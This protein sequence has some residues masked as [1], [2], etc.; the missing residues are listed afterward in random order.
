MILP[1]ALSLAL[2]LAAMA[3]AA[4]AATASY[5]FYVSGIKVGTVTLVTDEGAADYS[6]RAK[7][8][9]AGLLGVFLSFNYDGN[10]QGALSGGKPVPT[11]FTAT[12]VTSGTKKSTRIDWA[13]GAPAKVT[14]NPPRS[15]PLN[16]AA[17]QGTLD[18]VTAAFALLRDGPA[19]RMC[20]TKVELFDGSRRARITLG[21]RRAEKG[22]FACGGSYSRLEGEGNSLVSAQDSP[23]TLRFTQGSDGTARVRR[24]ETRTGFGSATLERRS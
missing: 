24:I 18:P 1:R 7:I 4:R 2:V 13:N 9:T 22:G 5:D 3:P 11:L 17:A 16:L 19:E 6:A 20:D 15:Q 21:P 10:A 8:S 14:V 23:F 12:S